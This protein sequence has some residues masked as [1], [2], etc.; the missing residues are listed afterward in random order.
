[1][2]IVIDMQG[3]QTESR[4]RGI[5]RYT[6]AFAQGVVRNRG[7]HEILLSL[8]GL[9][10]D[11]IEPIRAAFD[12]LLPQE[13]I[14][15][16]HAPGPVREDEPNNHCRREVAELIREA[17]LASLQPDVIHLTSLFEGY[18][19][20]AVTS[21]GLF[22]HQTPISVSLYDLIPLMNA[23][24]YLQPNPSYAAYYH[25]KI[26][27]LKQAK[28]CLAISI[29]ARKEGLAC[30]GGDASRIVNVST[31]IG[32]EFHPLAVDEE[33][34]HALRRKIGLTR[35]F[36]LYTGGSDERKNLPRLIEAWASLPRSL[37]TAHQLVFAGR[38]PEGHVAELRRIARS[39]GLQADELLFSG[40]VSD[41]ELVQLYNL[42]KLY[43]FPSWHEGFGLPALEAMACGAPVIGANTTSLPEVIGLQEALFDPLD[44]QSIC[45]KIRVA[46]SDEAFLARLRS[47]GIAQAQCFYWDKTAQLSIAAWTDHITPTILPAL[48]HTNLTETLASKLGNSN[49]EQLIRMAANIAQN[50]ATGIERQLFLDISELCQRDAATGV[51]RVVRSYLHHLLRSPPIG[52]RVRPVYATQTG[53]Y[54]YANAYTAKILDQAP[55]P[56]GDTEIRWQRGDLFFGLD[57]QHHVQ[58]AHA[59]VYARMRQD[60]VVVKFL[61][62][63]L[64]PIQL[65]E[66]F[67][68]GNV[69]ELHEQWLKMIARQDQAICVSKATAD[70]FQEWI[71]AHS[72]ETTS[73]FNIDWVH[74]GGDLEGS[75]PSRGLPVDASGTLR[76]LRSRPTFVA[77][78]T[79]EPRKAQA[80]ILDAVGQLWADGRDVNLVFVGQQ[81]WKTD[82]LVERINA[83]PENG[84]RLFWLKGISDEYLD[85]V[86][87]ASTCL[88]AAS[89]NEG[90]GLPLIE[91]ARHGIPVIARDIPVFRE[92]AGEAAFF[93]RGETGAHLA[94]AMNEWLQQHQC[95]AAP[96]STGMHWSTWQQSTEH[97]KAALVGRHYPR[98]QLLVDISE[99]VQ[100]DARTGIHRVVRSVLKEWLQNPPDGFRVEPVFATINRP[101]CYA[102]EFTCRFLGTSTEGVL[103]EPISHTPGDIFFGLDLN[104]HVP[105]VHQKFLKSM[106]QEGVDVRFMVYD[107]LPIQFPQFWE[108]QHSVH[109][110]VEEW[111]SVVAQLS[112]AVCISKA[113]ANDVA[114]WLKEADINRF[115]KFELTW[116]HL[117]ADSNK[118]RPSTGLSSNANKFLVQLKERASFLMVGTLE[119]RKGHAQVLDAFEQLWQSSV[120]VNL[121]IVG[122]QGWLVDSLVNQFRAHSE[123][124]KRLFWLEDISDEYLEEVYAASTCLIAASYGEGFGLP[125]IE[126]AQHKLPIIARDIPVFREIA[127]EH[128]YYFNAVQP[129]ELAQTLRHWLTLYRAEKHPRSDAMPWLTWKESAER[130]MQTLLEPTD[131]PSRSNA[132]IPNALCL[133]ESFDARENGACT[134]FST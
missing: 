78:S 27:F 31:A 10:P 89:I 47:H 24:Q 75:E 96:P 43:V 5:G 115:R 82:K 81:G 35:P 36:A 33:A 65:T 40:Y 132:L 63:D 76:T 46:L 34:A 14:R 30:L 90:F 84:R 23:A 97:L 88:V 91:A 61:I 4:F 21:I 106:Y 134:A 48:E 51:Q 66:F 124:D 116:F 83:H 1:M 114:A 95:G 3:A 53:R 98:R 67:E 70:A 80:Q 18:E 99:L 15:V 2:R 29:Y 26:R 6:L 57:M 13:N 9:F 105:R 108:P 16:W 85:C 8:N 104:H 28:L 131:K 7:A 129:G 77:V 74:N 37:R 50:E 69:K 54:R 111:M 93:F 107:L 127:G 45:D 56:N 121:V 68:D 117:G 125:L 44:P 113:V 126:A 55:Q 87:Q 39:K 123:L 19:Q 130:L 17:F 100:H 102:R 25:R 128:A 112:G 86:Y 52:F 73:S 71:A 62:H 59:D 79:L 32:P 72:I 109:L 122:K 110:V 119:P 58:L 101:Y 42:C 41:E 118:S 20:D 12:G 103:D 133:D 49:E 11:T 60:G 22:D 92:V 64:L 38:M 120:D 94:E